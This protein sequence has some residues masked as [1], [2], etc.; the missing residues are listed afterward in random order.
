M[1]DGLVRFMEDTVIVKTLRFLFMFAV[2]GGA[3]ITPN[4][5]A[6]DWLKTGRLLGALLDT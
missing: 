6:A 3:W 4:Q 5:C 2:L 1:V